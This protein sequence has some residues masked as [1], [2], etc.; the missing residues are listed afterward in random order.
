MRVLGIIIF[1]M[2]LVLIGYGLSPSLAVTEK[3]IEGVSGRDTHTTVWYV[4]G[5][6]ILALGG[7]SLAF[8]NSGRK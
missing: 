1:L 8:S 5:G 6:L 7:V 4:L 3:V 2:G